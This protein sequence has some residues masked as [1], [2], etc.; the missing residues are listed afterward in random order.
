MTPTSQD[1][2]DNQLQNLH[3]A[4]ESWIHTTLAKRVQLLKACAQATLDAAPEFVKES[5][6]AKQIDI[7]SPI[8]AEEW[9]GGPVCLVR[10]LRLMWEALETLEKKII[11]VIKSTSEPN[12]FFYD[13][14]ISRHNGGVIDISLLTTP[15]MGTKTAVLNHLKKNKDKFDYTALT[16]EEWKN[17]E[18]TDE[19][20]KELETELLKTL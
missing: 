16:F 20:L 5:C 3:A 11:Q 8:A 9:F 4:K 7:N 10:H 14:I 6:A 17:Q 1:E 18:I 15:K 2:L 19:Y 12:T 13:A